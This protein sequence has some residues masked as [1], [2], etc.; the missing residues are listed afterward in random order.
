MQSHWEI[1]VSH[2]GRHLFATSPRSCVSVQDY[3]RVFA[4]IE[5]R[6]PHAEGF[7]VTSTHWECRGRQV[8]A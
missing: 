1:C 3:E 6:F 7:H 8:V 4:A 5:Q 2:R